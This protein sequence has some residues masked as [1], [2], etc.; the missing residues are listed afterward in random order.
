MLLKVQSVTHRFGGLVA[1]NDVKVSVA[2]GTI[3]GLIGPNGAG[4]TTLF[5]ILSGSFRPTT[6]SLEFN[7]SDITR[8][9]RHKRCAL[10]IGRTYQVV[11]PFK[12]MSVEENVLV[13]C[14]VRTRQVDAAREVARDLLEQLGIGH[15]RHA[16]PLDL[17]LVLRKRLEVARALATQPRLLL[18]DEV[19]AGLNP[20]EIEEMLAL[21]REIRSGGVTVVI[22]EHLMHAISSVCDEVMVLNQ[23]KPIA[24]GTPKEVMAHPAVIEAYLGSEF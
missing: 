9:S 19:M 11:Q 10:G 18:L 24:A 14:L 3:H 17:P 13:G 5:N 2:E 23:G 15:L 6:G 7:G 16:D 20:V 1:L 22:I 4:K 21:I 8:T 12:G